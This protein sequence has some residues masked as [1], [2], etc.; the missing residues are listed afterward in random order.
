MRPTSK[1]FRLHA[2]RLYALPAL[3]ALVTGISTH[4]AA[5]TSSL[6][7][8]TRREILDCTFEVISILRDADGR[9]SRWLVGT[10]YCVGDGT[11]ATAA[12]VLDEALGGRYDAPVIRDRKGQIHS[13]DRVLRYSMPDDFVV[14]TA[15]G[16]ETRPAP[17]RTTPAPSQIACTSHRGAAIT[18]SP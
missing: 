14:F 1:H 16:L 13:I 8:A 6:D 2:F 15:K 18:I 17:P 7:P 12:H 9:P 3:F 10:A 4:A 11:L 5:S